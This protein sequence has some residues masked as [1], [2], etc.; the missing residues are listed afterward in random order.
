MH[1]T[2]SGLIDPGTCVEDADSV[3]CACQRDD[4]AIP[5]SEPWFPEAAIQMDTP[6]GRRLTFAVD[7]SVDPEGH[8]GAA[9]VS[10]RGDVCLRTGVR[11]FHAATAELEAVI[12]ALEAVVELAPRR[13]VILIDSFDALATAW[14]LQSNRQPRL[15]R[16]IDI[17][18]RNRLEDAMATI[19]CPLKLIKVKA[20]SQN[21]LHDAAD[22]VAWIGRRATRSPRSEMEPLLAE[23]LTAVSADVVAKAPVRRRR[24]WPLGIAATVG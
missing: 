15:D 23:N 18:V 5:L 1:S 6:I 12:L 11:R 24:K 10:T 14:C 16:G 22:H 3:T 20:H 9:A 13:A 7:G 19:D 4:A 2:S 8:W 17:E 21:T